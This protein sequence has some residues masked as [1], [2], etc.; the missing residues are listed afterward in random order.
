M[1]FLETFSKT[2]NFQRFVVVSFF[3]LLF[4]KKIHM[5]ILN[6]MEYI[7]NFYPFKVFSWLFKNVVQSL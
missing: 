5:S 6:R 7:L 1:L 2:A 4:E 3:G